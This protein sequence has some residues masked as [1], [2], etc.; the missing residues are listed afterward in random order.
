MGYFF[1]LFNFFILVV[2]D[3]NSIVLSSI[4]I[5]TFKMMKLLK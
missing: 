2:D 3:N 1:S 4:I 5:N